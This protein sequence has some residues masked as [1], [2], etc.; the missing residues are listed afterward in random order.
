MASV[1]EAIVDQQCG[2][3]ATGLEC[4]D[5]LLSDQ[6]ACMDAASGA[7][8]RDIERVACCIVGF[9]HD[10]VARLDAAIDRAVHAVGH[11]RWGSGS[12]RAGYAALGAVAEC[13]VVAVGV[14]VASAERAVRF[15]AV[16]GNSVAV[17]A[18]LVRFDHAIAAHRSSVGIGPGVDIGIGLGVHSGIG[19]GVN[20]RFGYGFNVR[21]RVGRR[22]R[23]FAVTIITATAQSQESQH[24]GVP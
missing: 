16:A 13:A 18:F 15:A 21:C 4:T 5:A 3:L 11:D 6:F 24:E 7:V 22:L 2:L 17:V 23:S 9:V 19:L 14:H 12:T 10:A 8:C 1:V 20:A